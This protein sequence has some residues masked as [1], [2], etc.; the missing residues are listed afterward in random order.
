MIKTQRTAGFSLINL[1]ISL[2]LLSV[3]LAGSMNLLSYVAT[4]TGKTD[5]DELL[6]QTT[7]LTEIFGSRVSR[8][9]AYLDEKDAAKGIQLCALNSTGTQCNTY[10]NQ[11]QNYCIA[12]ATQVNN[13]ALAKINIKGFRL[14][15]GTL[16]QREEGN[17]ETGIDLS[18]FNVASF[19]QNNSAWENLHNSDDFTINSLRLCQFKADSIATI[20]ANYANNCASVLTSTPLPYAY[21]IAL[22]TVS[23]KKIGADTLQQSRIIQLFNDTI[24]STL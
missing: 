22:F 16:Q 21:W 8:G 20:T 12:L 24:V 17:S 18:T 2:F 7:R 11:T 15:N 9:G 23:P 14:L 19:C 10:K 5:N 6:N 4:S 13:G 1:M 3:M